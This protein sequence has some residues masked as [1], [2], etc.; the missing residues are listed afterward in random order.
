MSGSLIQRNSQ[1]FGINF[2]VYTIDGEEFISMP[3]FAR[4][5]GYDSPRPLHKLIGRHASE[6]VNKT[7]VVNLTTVENQQVT[8]INREG[9]IRACMLAKAP[10]AKEFR[11][12]AEHI[13]FSVA[14]TGSYNSPVLTQILTTLNEA[15]LM[16]GKMLQNLAAEVYEVRDCQARTLVP[17]MRDN[18]NWPTPAQRLRELIRPKSAPKFFNGGA[19]FDEAA[20]HAYAAEFGGF[21]M[22]RERPR[23]RAEW[24]IEVTWE[25]DLF[26]LRFYK[27][28]LLTWPVKQ[29]TLRLLLPS[30]GG[31]CHV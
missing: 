31:R 26:L 14:T 22:K 24:V 3:Q 13:L 16:Q 30:K 28:F 8:L 2:E 6:F 27:K 15:I 4:G 19:K 10:R 12:V 20:A 7:R 11:D 5:L 29:D 1:V 17:A 9:V 18:R 23:K 21:P 25:N